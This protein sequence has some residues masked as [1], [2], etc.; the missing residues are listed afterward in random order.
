MLAPERREALTD[1]PADRRH[2]GSKVRG[3]LG[4][5]GVLEGATG[6]DHHDEGRAE[7]QQCAG[8]GGQ[9]DAQR[10]GHGHMVTELACLRGAFG[11]RRRSG[12]P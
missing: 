6:P 4:R 10:A 1:R 7:D 2:L 11:L 12:H 5:T 9:D 3:R 8:D